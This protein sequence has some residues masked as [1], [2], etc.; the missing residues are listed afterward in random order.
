MASF[1][2]AQ[3]HSE[4]KLTSVTQYRETEESIKCILT[5][6][7]TLFYHL[8]MLFLVLASAS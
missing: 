2:L 7:D 6:F 4:H 1:Q 5:H 8:K 3:L